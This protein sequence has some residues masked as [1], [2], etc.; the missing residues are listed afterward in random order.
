MSQFDFNIDADYLILSANIMWVQVSY[1]KPTLCGHTYGAV[2]SLQLYPGSQ[3][4]HVVCPSSVALVPGGQRLGSV[5]SLHSNP[6][7]HLS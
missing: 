4:G 6:I 2:G 3:S 1:G 5:G 7:G